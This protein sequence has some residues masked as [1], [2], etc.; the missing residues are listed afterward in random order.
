MYFLHLKD[1][2]HTHLMSVIVPAIRTS[3]NDNPVLPIFWLLGRKTTHY[4]PQAQGKT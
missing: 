4:Q 1:Q 2:I 3:H